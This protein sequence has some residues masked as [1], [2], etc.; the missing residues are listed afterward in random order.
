MKLKFS[1]CRNSKI[2][3]FRW[4]VRLVNYHILLDSTPVNFYK[5][6]QRLWITILLVLVK[7]PK[8]VDLPEW[9][10]YRANT[11]KV[12]YSEIYG[13]HYT[14]NFINQLFLKC[15]LRSIFKFPI[16]ITKERHDSLFLVKLYLNPQYLY[17][18]NLIYQN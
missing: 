14:W 16:S 7:I 4:I 8:K 18:I 10:F 13:V 11:Q 9:N 2:Y 12:N 6:L 3:V 15:C 5:R 17:N 1:V